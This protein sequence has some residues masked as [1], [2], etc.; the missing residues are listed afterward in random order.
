MFVICS[1]YTLRAYPV[2]RN[3]S[4]HDHEGAA[5]PREDQLELDTIMLH[6]MSS[7]S[8]SQMHSGDILL[9]ASSCLDGARLAM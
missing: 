6:P 2:N 9:M 1:G 3:L 4:S 7:D 8:E 5:V